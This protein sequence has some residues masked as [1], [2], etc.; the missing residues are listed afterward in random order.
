MTETQGLF[1]LADS[2]DDGT[3]ENGDYEIIPLSM[4]RGGEL[5]PAKVY[6][7][8]MRHIVND[9]NPAPRGWYKNKH[10]P[11]R[12]RPRPCYTEAVL[13]VP[14]GGYC[15][16]GCKFC[17]VDNGTRGYRST[18]IPTVSPSYPDILRRKIAKMQIANAFYISSFTEPFQVLEDRYHITQRLTQVL[19]AE[20]L[21]LFYLSRRIPPDWAIDALQ[22]NPY[23]YMQWSINSS[24]SAIYKM[25]SPGSYTIPEVMTSMRQLADLGIYIS[26]Q[27]NPVLPGIVSLDD[28]KELVRL[29]A[30]NGGRHVIFKFV[31]Q[32]TGGRKILLERLKK[33]PGV[34]KLDECLTQV[35]GGVYTIDQAMRVDWLN[36]L[37]IETRKCG[38]TMSTCYEYYADGGAG[39]NLA[40]Y[41]TTSDQCHGRGVPMFYR[42]EPDARFEPLPGCYRK[43][44]LYCADFGTKACGN[45]ILLQA[46]AL[47]YKDYQSITLK[48]N[49]SDW[50]LI[51]SCAMPDKVRDGCACNDNLLTDMELWEL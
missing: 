42:P 12:V 3:D 21:P 27:C 51:D 48:G 31:E 7:R 41:F 22:Q 39:A 28:L 24:D 19:A 1:K 32:V 6:K 8:P 26:V 11:G 49:D 13:T 44:C 37:L 34:G 38:I 4:I 30:A 25:M 33:L 46:K 29:I 2:I 9:S 16:I 14:Y 20:G 18:G 5:K 47:V 17:Y 45:E 23:S 50:G 40:P 10:E 35:I 36:A 15:H 43:G